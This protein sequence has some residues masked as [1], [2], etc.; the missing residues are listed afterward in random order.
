MILASGSH[1]SRSVLSQACHL[2]M[3]SS[4]LCRSS[5]LYPVRDKPKEGLR[6]TLI[7]MD[8]ACIF[9]RVC[10]LYSSLYNPWQEEGPVLSQ[11]TPCC[12]LIIIFFCFFT[13]LALFQSCSAVQ[14]TTHC[15]VTRVTM[16]AGERWNSWGLERETFAS[17]VAL[18]M[19]ATSWV[20]P[21]KTKPKPLHSETAEPVS[22]RRK[23]MERL[24]SLVTR[25]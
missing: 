2:A 14:V 20:N 1:A 9:A 23:A 10:M 4:F 16:G 22:Q 25:N 5:L 11:L 3:Q 12:W 21:P 15:A 19:S 24:R 17:A 8:T 18:G 7:K 6:M 13:C